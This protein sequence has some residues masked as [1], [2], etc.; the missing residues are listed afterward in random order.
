MAITISYLTRVG[1][2]LVLLITLKEI[3]QNLRKWLNKLS[4][5]SSG[6]FVEVSSFKKELDN[7]L[8]QLFFYLVLFYCLRDY[9]KVVSFN[10]TNL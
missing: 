6:A 7:D 2:T 8:I 3:T 10:T 4:W 9:S 1:K 5:K